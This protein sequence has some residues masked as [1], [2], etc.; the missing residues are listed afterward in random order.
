MFLTSWRLFW[1]YDIQIFEIKKSRVVD[2]MT[3]FWRHGVFWSHD[4]LF[5]VMTCL[6]C[7]G[8]C[9]T[10]W[11]TFWRHD[12]CLTFFDIMTCF[13]RHDKLVGVMT[14]FYLAVKWP[15]TNNICEIRHSL[16]TYF[17][18]YQSWIQ[19]LHIQSWRWRGTPRSS[20]SVKYSSDLTPYRTRGGLWFFK[21]GQGLNILCIIGYT[22]YS[23]YINILYSKLFIVII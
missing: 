17:I 13:W 7:H 21:L 10:S 19:R 18:R 11:W 2:V 5:D 15:I 4:E 12:I 20:F 14:C 1:L 8:V 16:N 9:L 6:W 22:F 3:N 23:F